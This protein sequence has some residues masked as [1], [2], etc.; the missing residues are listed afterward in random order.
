M[1][2][3]GDRLKK[4]AD[5]STSDTKPLFWMLLGPLSVMLTLMV[6]IPNFSAPYLPLLTVIGFVLCWCYRAG[7]FSLILLL[8]VLYFAFHYFFGQHDAFL[9]KAGWGC[10]LVLGLT[11]AFLAMEELKH[12]YATEKEGKEKALEQLRVSLRSFE[13]KRAVEKGVLENEIDR[14]KGELASSGEEAEVLLNLVDVSRIESDK[15]YQQ[16]ETLA[17]ESIALQ[18]E[19]E[20]FKVDLEQTREK[21]SRFE[22]KH[23]EVSNIAGQRL[24][25]LNALRVDLYQ[26]H[27]LIEGYRE[28]VERGRL[29]V[30]AKQKEETAVP[31]QGVA[32]MP[33]ENERC[34]ALKTLEKDKKT[35]KNNYDQTL[36]GYRK[37]KKA[38]D[39]GNLKLRKGA[40][41]ALKVEMNRLDAGVKEK[42]ME[43]E[44]TKSELIG[45]EREIFIIKKRLRE[46][47][48]FA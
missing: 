39:E 10:S 32:S 41:K 38:L 9:W 33:K 25:Q 45:I 16:S 40:D 21:L 42:K 13:E 12:Y 20:T 46:K 7:G 17:T 35:I 34:P 11:I 8:F 29:Y 31:V 26:S 6:P 24:K 30:Q 19:L 37:L 18:R 15:F 36:K 48:S 28:K 47:G 5:F 14:L 1:V 22:I 2:R 23:R 27:L 4:W 44:Q 3:A 43:L